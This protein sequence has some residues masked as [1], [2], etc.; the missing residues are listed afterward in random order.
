MKDYKVLFKPEGKEISI[1]EGETILEAANQ[2]GI[3][4]NSECGG[5]RCLW[6]MQGS[7]TGR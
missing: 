5:G 2:A 7:G 3:Y 1:K 4:I 6:K